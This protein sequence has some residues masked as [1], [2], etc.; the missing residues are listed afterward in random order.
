VLARRYAALAPAP[1]RLAPVFASLYPEEK[2]AYIQDALRAAKVSSLNHDD[3]PI[4]Y[5]LGSRLL[6]WST[7][8][9]MSGLFAWFAKF[10]FISALTVLALLML[11]PF[12]WALFRQRDGINAIPAVLAAA[13]GGFAGLSFEITAIFIFQNTWG[14]IYQAI[15]MLIALFMMGLGAGAAWTSGRIANKG[16]S[17]A[18]AARLL[19]AGLVLIS[20]ASPTFLVLRTASAFRTGAAGQLLLVLGLGGMGVLA[21]AILPLGMRVLDRLP[22]GRSAGFLNSGDYLGGAAGSVLTAAFFLPL[23]G[24]RNSLILIS[25]VALTAALALVVAAHAAGGEK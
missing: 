14:F 19:A 25:F 7:G 6:G 18:R 23:L 24:T 1:A 4:A 17:P 16:T 21:G 13:G 15:G 20:L 11:P 2:G 10:T 22:A 5:F 9:P 12:L 3:R 8:S